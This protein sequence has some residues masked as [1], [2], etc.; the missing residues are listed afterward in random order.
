M[1][2]NNLPHNPV[3]IIGI[4][5]MFAKSSDAK[6]FLHLLTRG[7]NGITDPPETHR[8]LNEFLDP[9]PKKPDHIYCNRGGYLPQVDFDPSEFGIPPT[10]LEATDTSQLLG[11]VV[12]KQALADAGYGEDARPFDREKTSVILGV[13]GTQE[14]VIPLGGRLGHPIWRRAL[15]EAGISGE[16]ADAVVRGISEGYVA[17]QENSFPGLLGNVVAGRIANRLDLGGTNCVVDAACASSM[18]AIHMSLLELISGRSDMVLTG[19]VDTINDAFMHMCFSKTQILSKDG[20]IRPFSK[21]ASGT[22]LGEGL[23]MLVLKRLEDARRDGDRIYA[24]IRGIGSGSDGKSQSIY[25][26][27]QSGQSRALRRAYDHA[28]VSPQSISLVE[29]HGTG[30][31]VGDQVEFKAL[32]DVFGTGKTGVNACALGS[33]KSNIGHTKAAAGT[34]G[35]IK[36]ALSLYHK[37]LMPTLKAQPIDPNLGIEESPFYINHH[38]RPWLPKGAENSIRRAGVSAFGFGG[39]NFH[40][41]LEEFQPQ[42]QAPSWDGTVEIVALSADTREELGNRLKKLADR[43]IAERE[44]HRLSRLAAESRRRFNSQDVCRLLIVIEH[45]DDEAHVRAHLQEAAQCL[46]SWDQTQFKGHSATIFLGSGNPAAKRVAFLFPGQGSQYVG[47]G[48]DLI[49]TFPEA[50]EAFQDAVAAVPVQPS[51]DDCIFPRMSAGLD[52]DEACLRRTEIAQPAIGAVSTAMLAAL[53]Y[54]G[55]YPTAVCG[56]SYGELTALHAAGWIDNSP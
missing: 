27:R 50:L 56:H 22:V 29:A 37:V 6:S 16:Q 1:K 55:V 11:L 45:P 7:I 53:G 42:K 24:V 38:L 41:V 15:D 30:T 43:F 36:S 2:K 14:L 21:D 32:C 17:W 40:A 13:T 8:H 31:R 5:C 33:V 20:E 18:G 10:A 35:L 39:S 9:D 3:A 25:A 28:G 12:A 26:P 46:Q 52:S 54:F 4:G 34:A 49:C 48:R 19:G 44:S 23:G 47:M 51:L